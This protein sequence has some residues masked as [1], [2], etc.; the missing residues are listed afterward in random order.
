MT[1]HLFNLRFDKTQKLEC[2]EDIRVV[3]LLWFSLGF[4]TAL[5]LFSIGIY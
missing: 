3:R 2:K 4:I 1:K 5:V